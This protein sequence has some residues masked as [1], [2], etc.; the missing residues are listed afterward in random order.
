[1][2]RSIAL[3]VFCL[4]LV[5][6]DAASASEPTG[7]YVLVEKVELE[8]GKRIRIFGVFMNDTAPE[9][10]PEP[11]Y[12]PVSGWASF[13]L[14]ERKQDLARLEWE[15]IKSA[16][17]KG[18]VLALGSAY[19]EV[20][21]PAVGNHVSQD[22]EQAREAEYPVGHGLYLMRDNSAPAIKLLDFRKSNPAPK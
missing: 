3:A 6:V 2:M 20:F 4:F 1:M 16:E 8:P 15:D 22:R 7:L 13:R 14:P 21:H 18:K 5:Q 9:T 12:G 19:A 10:S 17:G 11:F